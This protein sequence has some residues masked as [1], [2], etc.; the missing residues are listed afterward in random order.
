M[1]LLPSGVVDWDAPGVAV[2]GGVGCAGNSSDSGRAW[3][4][5]RER[6]V[7]LRLVR[8][9]NF[10][11]DAVSQRNLV[12]NEDITIATPSAAQEDDARF[13]SYGEKGVGAAGWAMD[14]V[15]R[16]QAVLLAFDDSDTRAG[17]NK[18]VFLVVELA[19]VLRTALSR[20]E[21]GKVAADL[22]EPTSVDLERA[23]VAH[24]LVGHPRQLAYVCDER[25]IHTSSSRQ[26]VATR[27]AHYAST[28]IS[29][30]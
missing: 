5:F 6:R 13:V 27:S 18:E 17:E 16:P 28:S 4:H 12:A 20:L 10:D 14:E 21:H 26:G 25:T 11:A 1:P 30:P 15:P 22:L 8:G 9:L 7:G 24:R 2:V 19:M 23:D 3:L 29:R